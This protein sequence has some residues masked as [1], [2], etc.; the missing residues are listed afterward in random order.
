[1]RKRDTKWSKMKE[2]VCFFR[3]I[4]IVKSKQFV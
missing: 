4:I 1:M 2:N 3:C